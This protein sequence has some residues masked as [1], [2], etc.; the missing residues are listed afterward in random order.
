MFQSLVEVVLHDMKREYLKYRKRQPLF[1]A[2]TL[3]GTFNFRVLLIIY[4][5]DC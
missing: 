1:L 5:I 3:K 2:F 4:K